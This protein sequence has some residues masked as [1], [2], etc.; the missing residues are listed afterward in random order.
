MTKV[1]SYALWR[2]NLIPRDEVLKNEMAAS[3][4][5]VAVAAKAEKVTAPKAPKKSKKPTEKK[6]EKT[7]EQLA[8]EQ[9][10]EELQAEID[11]LDEDET[12][13]DETKPSDFEVN[14]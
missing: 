13:G 14:A 6:V 11:A 4:K 5:D 2:G 1:V 9:E 10:L 7:A 12:A 8:E 3:E